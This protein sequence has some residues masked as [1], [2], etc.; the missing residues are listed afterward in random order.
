[1]LVLMLK[2]VHLTGRPEIS[3]DP[4][5]II[6][7][8]TGKKRLRKSFDFKDPWARRKQARLDFVSMFNESL[9]GNKIS[10][11]DLSAIEVLAKLDALLEEKKNMFGENGLANRCKSPHLTRTMTLAFKRS[12]GCD[13]DGSLQEWEGGRKKMV[14]NKYRAERGMVALPDGRLCTLGEC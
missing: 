5:D 4:D 12:R 11:N 1:M 13:Y 8:K 10:S 7:S 6:V 2:N 3:S 14:L 9:N